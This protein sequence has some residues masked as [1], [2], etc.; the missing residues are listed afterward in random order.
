[1]LLCH[2]FILFVSHIRTFVSQAHTFVSQILPS[3]W[4][5]SFSRA[6]CVTLSC[7]LCHAFLPF[8]SCILVSCHTFLLYWLV[9]FITFLLVPHIPAVMSPIPA[10][11]SRILAVVS[12]I[13]VSIPRILLLSLGAVMPCIL[14]VMSRILAIL[15]RFLISVSRILA[16]MSRVIAGEPRVDPQVSAAGKEGVQLEQ[17]GGHW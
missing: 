15:S 11:M 2:R 14:T 7:I 5:L 4:Y 8:V 13:L 17:T 1:M 10:I 6:F 3:L 16:Y 12:R 9:F